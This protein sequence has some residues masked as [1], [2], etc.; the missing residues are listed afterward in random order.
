MLAPEVG[1]KKAWISTF[2]RVGMQLHRRLKLIQPLII[3]STC[4]SMFAIAPTPAIADTAVK[5]V[6]DDVCGNQQ[7]DGIRVCGAQIR[8]DDEKRLHNLAD[9]VVLWQRTGSRK[10]LSAY[11]ATGDP[12]GFR[13]LV[14]GDH[15][16]PSY[17]Q[18]RVSPVLF[19]GALAEALLTSANTTNTPA[20]AGS[21]ITPSSSIMGCVLQ[22]GRA[23]AVSLIRT[24]LYSRKEQTAAAALVTR[25]AQCL[26]TDETIRLRMAVLRSIVAIQLFAQSLP[27]LPA[28]ESTEPF[29]ADIAATALLPLRL[30]LSSV[31]ALADHDVAPT[32]SIGKPADASEAAFSDFRARDTAD[33]P[34]KFDPSDALAHDASPSIDPETGETTKMTSEHSAR[35][36]SG[37]PY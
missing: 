22:S 15:S 29:R 6:P 36:K 18:V 8:K 33:L 35:E 1:G 9:C 21:A 31:P 28:R 16:C 7:G 5:I 12:A 37:T 27:A 3:V 13:T 11:V 17:G 4:V 25:I 2:A 24:P 14:A 34:E 26:P 30:P 19:A 23:E 32:L 10:M 20:G